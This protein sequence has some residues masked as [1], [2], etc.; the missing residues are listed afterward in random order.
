M[1]PESPPLGTPYSST[2]P[3]G[4]A[5]PMPPCFVYQTLP[6]GP[7][8]MPMGPVFVVDV[9][10]RSNIVPIVVRLPM[11]LGAVLWCVNQIFPSGPA[12]I[13][14]GLL[15]VGIVNSVIVMPGPLMFIEAP[16]A[17]VGSG[18]PVPAAA[19]ARRPAPAVRRARARRAR[20]G[21]A[22]ARAAPCPSS[23]CPP[24]PPTSRRPPPEVAAAAAA[25]R[26]RRARGRARA[27]AAALTA[28]GAAERAQRE[29]PEDD[30]RGWSGVK[31]R[32]R[33]RRA[34]RRR[35]S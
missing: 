10:K 18:T 1:P 23:R 20:A 5:R 3:D 21:A 33:V 4:C 16:A 8:A 6:S 22:R 12:Q 14:P 2:V 11:A 26:A 25:G 31:L 35:R 29:P 9:L 7:P 32:M 24:R 34:G 30:E 27:V 13:Q 17:P 19:R 15:G 28:P